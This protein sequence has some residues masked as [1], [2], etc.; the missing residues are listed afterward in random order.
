MAKRNYQVVDGSGDIIIDAAGELVVI[1]ETWT[2]TKNSRA[3]G[4]F[5]K[6]TRISVPYAKRARVSTTWVKDEITD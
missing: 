3:A 5:T 2:W 1:E 6:T 4:S